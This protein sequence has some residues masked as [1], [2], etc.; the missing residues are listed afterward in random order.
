M[1]Y[2]LKIYSC[3]L[4]LATCYYFSLFIFLL[5]VFSDALGASLQF[6][7]LNFCDKRAQCQTCLT[8]PSG[9]KIK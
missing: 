2:A 6:E 1:L 4:L 9:A 3:D 7:T 5:F 8:M